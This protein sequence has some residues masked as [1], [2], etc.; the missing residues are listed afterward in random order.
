M[1]VSPAQSGLTVKLICC[2]AF[3]LEP[4]ACFSLEYIAISL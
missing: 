1:Y 4:S 3:G 2:I